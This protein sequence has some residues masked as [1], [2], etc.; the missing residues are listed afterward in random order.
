MFFAIKDQDNFYY[1]G[2]NHWD[3][4]LRKATLYSSYDMAV[5]CR[6]DKRFIDRKPY[7]VGVEIQEIGIYDK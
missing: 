4:Q 7:I 2:Y 3:N 6:D 1:C 5:K